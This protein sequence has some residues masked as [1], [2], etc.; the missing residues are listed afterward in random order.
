MKHLI[1]ID[2]GTTGAKSVLINERG[3]VLAADLQEY[4]LSMP[5]PG[6][7]EQNPEHWVEATIRSLR[8]LLAKSGVAGR[9]LAGLSFSGQMHGL[10]CL[11][12]DGRVL[13]PAILWCDTRTT[14]ECRLIEE[15][16]GGRA[17]LI[18]LASNPALEGFTLP[19][20]V[21]VQRHDPE[22]FART[23]MILLPKD[24]VRFRLTGELGMDMSDA[25]GTL[26]LDVKGRRWSKAIMGALGLPMSL[27]PPLGE[28]PDIAGKIT[29]AAAAE[30]GLPEGL[31]VAFGGADNTCAAIGN[32]VTEEGTVAIS[33]GTSGTVIA[34]TARPVRDKLG[35]AHTF[36]HSVPGLWYVMGVMQ[37]AGLSLKWLRDNFAGLER[38]MA[39]E[40]GRDAYE[41]LTAGAEG[42]AAG[43]D[44]LLWLPYL[45]GERTPHLDANAR[46]VL[47]G[48]A[49]H[50]TKAHVVRA[51][52]EGVAFGLRDSLEIIRSLKI[53]VNEIRITGGG[54]KSPL[55]RQIVADVL[56]HPVVTINVEEG[57]AFGAAI[58]AGVATGVFRDFA[59]ATNRIIRV[60]QQVNPIAANIAAYEKPYRLYGKLYGDLRET[61]AETA[62]TSAAV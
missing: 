36:N 55:W 30:T 7:A 42:I 59:H 13:R 62:R 8:N 6:W 29:P 49:A 60:T 50:H 25:A 44:G 31:P 24:Y 32:G 39:A 40:T 9:D 35:R 57:P 16:V 51:I 14:E 10:V 53:P 38:A 1:G 27:L 21:W 33:I 54:G 23:R 17:K 61:F 19:K 26:M 45:N 11:D 34:P 43:S 41:Y 46:A 28:S 58:I 22:V 37:A 5:R 52:L 47:F 2:I 4:P 20:L 12:G 56:G 18:Q 15:K 48:L 3:K